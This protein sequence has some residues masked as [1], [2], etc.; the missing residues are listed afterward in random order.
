MAMFLS[1]AVLILSF[2]SIES[3]P[4]CVD[5]QPPFKP[6]AKHMWCRKYSKLGCCTKRD[7]RNLNILYAK[8]LRTI[9]AQNRSK[10]RRYLAKV[11][12]LKCHPWSAHLFDVEANPNYDEKVALP[13]LTWKFCT[14]FVSRCAPAIEYIY[15][16]AMNARNITVGDFCRESEVALN[17]DLCYPKI[18]KTIAELKNPKAGVNIVAGIN[19]TNRGCLCVREVC[20]KCSAFYILSLA[21]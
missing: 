21:S 14:K 10:C 18:K 19:A 5:S 3:H 1:L 7:D 2:C 11:I 13:C 12:C 4:Q 6:N 16:N 8:A 20:S 17:K 15:G 9:Q